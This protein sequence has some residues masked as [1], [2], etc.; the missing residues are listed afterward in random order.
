M[1]R[2]THLAQSVEKSEYES[3]YD[4]YAKDLVSNKQVLARIAKGVTNELKSLLM[5]KFKKISSGLQFSFT[6]NIL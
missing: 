4:E 6:R 2:K 1:L 5:L 3:Q